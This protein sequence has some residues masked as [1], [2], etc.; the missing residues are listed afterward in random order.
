MLV[1]VMSP[2]KKPLPFT[3]SEANGEVVPIPTLP[4]ART[5][6]WVVVAEAVDE[7]MAKRV[8]L[9]VSAVLACTESRAYGDVEP[10]ARLPR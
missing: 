2:P 5:T 9:Y 4:L 8:P 6:K 7:A 3:E 10:S 1:A